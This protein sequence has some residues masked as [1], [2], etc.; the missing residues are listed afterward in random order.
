VFTLSILL[1]AVLTVINGESP[2]VFLM[3]ALRNMLS[4]IAVGYETITVVRD[5]FN[6]TQT[7]W[8]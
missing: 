4:V 1:L 7:Y 2:I 3:T 6:A 5:N 8:W